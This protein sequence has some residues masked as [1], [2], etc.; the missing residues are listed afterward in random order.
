MF[1]V[2]SEFNVPNYRYNIRVCDQ[3]AFYRIFS[4]FT[5]I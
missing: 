3:N 1:G 4:I 5:E 2:L